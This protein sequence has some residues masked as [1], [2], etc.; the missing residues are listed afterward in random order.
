M[1]E[2]VEEKLPI[3]DFYKVE[4]YVTVFKSQKWWKAIAIYQSGSRRALGIYLWVNRNGTWKRKQKL[5]IVDAN[6]WKKLKDSVEQ[7]LPKLV[8]K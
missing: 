4:E 8:S 1:T 6:E 5:N 3:S 7:L 2:K